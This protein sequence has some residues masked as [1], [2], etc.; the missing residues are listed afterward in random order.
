MAYPPRPFAVSCSEADLIFFPVFRR[1]G[2]FFSQRRRRQFLI[3]PIEIDVANSELRRGLRLLIAILRE[4]FLVIY[5]SPDVVCFCWFGYMSF[6]D[7]FF[8]ATEVPARTSS[9][10][11][12]RARLSELTFSPI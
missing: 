3:G 7:P 9:L 12:F 10:F 4:V 11:F 5:F 2:S 6:L 1:S 8:L